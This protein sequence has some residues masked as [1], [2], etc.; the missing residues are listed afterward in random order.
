[1]DASAGEPPSDPRMHKLFAD[2]KLCRLASRVLVRS[3]GNVRNRENT[4]KRCASFITPPPFLL[5]LSEAHER[6]CL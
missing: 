2:G 3:D 4:R 1:M 5:L 6:R